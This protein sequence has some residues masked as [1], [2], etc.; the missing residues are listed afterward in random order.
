ME[1]TLEK[2]IQQLNMIE[3]R[4]SKLE[5]KETSSKTSRQ[6]SQKTIKIKKKPNDK[7]QTNKNITIK[8][9]NIVLTKHPNG[10]IVTGDTY[11]KKTIIKK[12]KGWWTP[13]AKGWT[14]K[15][16]NF[17][18]LKSDLEASSKTIVENISDESLDIGESKKVVNLPKEV[19]TTG[20]IYD[21]D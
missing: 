21:S 16:N 8:T 13:E 20:F 17:E 15:L 9:G 3:K 12:Y 14:V 6:T 7:A 11:D 5:N 18:E 19:N 2:I 1:S 4:L 10:C